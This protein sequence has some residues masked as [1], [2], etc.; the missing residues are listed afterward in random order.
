MKGSTVTDN[1]YTYDTVPEEIYGV[2]PALETVQPKI[3]E[4]LQ[5]VLSGKEYTDVTAVAAHVFERKGYYSFSDLSCEPNPSRNLENEDVILQVTVRVHCHKVKELADFAKAEGE[6]TREE[7]RQAQIADIEL[8]IEQ[9]RA[10][11]AQL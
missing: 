7:A 5:A 4:T 1:T 8:Q 6:R 10:R 2:R 11:Q 9:L 3:V